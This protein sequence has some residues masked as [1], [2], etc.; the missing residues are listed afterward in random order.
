MQ[1]VGQGQA[2]AARGPIFVPDTQDI[3]RAR[4]GYGQDKEISS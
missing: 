4:P 3:A 2:G 1:A